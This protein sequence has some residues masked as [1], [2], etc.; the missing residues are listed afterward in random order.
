MNLE[1]FL[2]LIQC[3]KVW[4][5]FLTFPNYVCTGFWSKNQN[6]FWGGYPLLP[7]SKKFRKKS[8]KYLC[9]WPPIFILQ[10]LSTRRTKMFAKNQSSKEWKLTKLLRFE[11]I[12]QFFQKLAL[13]T[14]IW[15]TRPILKQLGQFLFW[16]VRNACLLLYNVLKNWLSPYTLA[17][18]CFF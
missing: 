13:E 4:N 8:K 17:C 14:K 6:I 1:F 15:I 3:F 2:W 9:T 7:P 12:I 16:I 5:F 10:S 11:R 18:S